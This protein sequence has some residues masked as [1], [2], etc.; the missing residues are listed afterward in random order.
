[1]T[2]NSAIL[3]RLLITERPSLIRLA[4]RILGSF[5]AAEDVTQSVWFKIQ[6]VE[7]DPPIH[8]PRAYLYRLTS[9][10]ASDHLR[11]DNTRK[12]LL[13]QDWPEHEILD[14]QPDAETR[15][16]DQERLA[17]FSDALEELP[18]RCREVFILRRIEGLTAQEIAVKL[19]I[20]PNAVAKHVRLA[21]HHC[22]T[23]L[24]DE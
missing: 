15:V 16:I 5:S 6:R 8:N 7:D 18:L 14:A 11:A 13:G 24:N 3:S 17:L 10:L 23:R 9:N 12:R 20:T 2:P 4:Q 21:L 22:Y 19:N 1:M